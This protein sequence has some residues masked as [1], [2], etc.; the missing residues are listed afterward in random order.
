MTAMCRVAVHMPMGVSVSLLRRR[1]MRLD[2]YPQSSFH[3]QVWVELL[4][5]VSLRRSGRPT[6]QT[7][8]ACAAF[9]IHTERIAASIQFE[10]SIARCHLWPLMIVG[11][12]S[13]GNSTVSSA[14]NP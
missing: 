11:R 5:R 4:V 14:R 13:A 8:S 7:S 2:G 3:P 12:V 6:H 9:T 10:N 1:G